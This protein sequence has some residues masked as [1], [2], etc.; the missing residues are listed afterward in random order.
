MFD[1]DIHSHV[2]PILFPRDGPLAMD[3]LR[4]GG[5]LYQEWPLRKEV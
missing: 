3:D 4:K 1:V 2:Q 5:R